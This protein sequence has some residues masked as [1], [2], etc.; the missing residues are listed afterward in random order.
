M[1]GSKGFTLT[2]L[3]FA[4]TLSA[5]VFI[6]II[7]VS[8]QMVRYQVESYRKGEVS[9]WTLVAQNQMSREL[10]NASVLDCPQPAAGGAT[11]TAGCPGVTSSFLRGCSNYSRTNLGKI[12]PN[13]SVP[14][15]AFYYCVPTSGVYANSLLRYEQLTT[16]DPR[17]CVINPT[18]GDAAPVGQSLSLIAK[19]VYQ[20]DSATPYF[21]RADDIQGVEINYIVGFATPTAQSGPTS[22]GP[23]PVY[24]RFNARIGMNK[25]IQTPQVD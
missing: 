22:G 17:T 25:S 24:V 19:N 5:L 18:C 13:P 10:E 1:S 21:T 3:I 11:Y 9:G 6:G 8:A 2:E 4:T 15:V 12:D 20:H 16:V 7:G 23:N 14:T